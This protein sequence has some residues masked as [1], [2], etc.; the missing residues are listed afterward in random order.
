MFLTIAIAASELF[1][2]RFPERIITLRNALLGPIFHGLRV[3]HTGLVGD[4]LVCPMLGLAGFAAA[5]TVA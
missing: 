1:R 3:L 2:A 4:D 5:L